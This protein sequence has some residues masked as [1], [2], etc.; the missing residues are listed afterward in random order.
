MV[1]ILIMSAK[2]IT[3]GLLKIKMFQNKSSD[4]IIPDYGVTNKILFR[5]LSY[6]ADVVM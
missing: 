1:R 6:I 2:L 4:V 5:D 3:P